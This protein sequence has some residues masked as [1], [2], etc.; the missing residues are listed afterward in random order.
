MKCVDHQ[1]VRGDPTRLSTLLAGDRSYELA[2][3]PMDF[4]VAATRG[5]KLV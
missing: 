3:G 5:Q 4:T 2:R 1:V